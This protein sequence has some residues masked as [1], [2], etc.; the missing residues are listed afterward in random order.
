MWSQ[1][2]KVQVYWILCFPNFMVSLILDFIFA[3]PE[4]EKYEY[5]ILCSVVQFPQFLIQENRPPSMLAVA[6]GSA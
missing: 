1:Q 6:N 4:Y 2:N 5:L 3:V